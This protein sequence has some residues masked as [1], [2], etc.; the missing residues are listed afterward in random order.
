MNSGRIGSVD[1]LRGMTMAL[2]LVVDNPGGAMY[3]PFNHADWNGFTPTDFVF[4]AFVFVMG[5]SMYLS[6][7]KSSF[8]LS[9]RVLRRFLLLFGVGLLLNWVGK[10]L[11][12]RGW[13]LE[14]LRILGVLQRLALCY[15]V[16]ALLVCLVDHKWLGWIAAGLLAAYG[17]L[18]LA[19]HGYVQG[20]ENILARVDAAVLGPDHIYRWGNGIDPEGMLSTV[21]A[22]AHT[23]IGFLMGKLL[24]S[25]ELRKM[26][27]SGTLLLTGGFLL[28]WVLPLNKKIWSPSFVLVAC[29]MATLLLAAFH[30]L[31]DER[32]LWK[33]TGFWKVFGSNA[34]LSF[35]LCDILVWVMN[36]SGAHA[37]IMKAVGNTPVTSLLYALAGLLLIWLLLLP[38]YRRKI[39]VRL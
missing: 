10:G 19:G 1:V 14:G 21:P 23:I 35:I 34:I 3:A 9:W 8:R 20:P 31:I 5:V 12:G 11:F 13:G 36:L 32:K 25:G 37:T 15:G 26:T 2:M 29:G 22:V 4:P 6:L 18:L 38:L 33:H 16:T 7:R 27:T 17:A 28:L 39:Y 30:D 24:V